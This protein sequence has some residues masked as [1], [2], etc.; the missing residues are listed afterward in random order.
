MRRGGA[1]S[2]TLTGNALPGFASTST[3]SFCPSPAVPST[4][5][6]PEFQLGHA[7]TSVRTS[8]TRSGAASIVALAS[9]CFIAPPPLSLLGRWLVQAERR[10]LV[11]GAELE[12]PEPRLRLL[13]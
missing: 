5:L 4:R 8:P 3:L 1:S 6:T 7:C 12:A 10:A 9:K 13:V 11:V 2:V